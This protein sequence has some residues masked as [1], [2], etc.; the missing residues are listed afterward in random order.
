MMDFVFESSWWPV[1]RVSLIGL[2]FFLL[3]E[4]VGEKRSWGF[5]R[6]FLFILVIAILFGALIG[7]LS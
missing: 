2:P 3:A 1:L 5:G 6:K 7:F 4:L